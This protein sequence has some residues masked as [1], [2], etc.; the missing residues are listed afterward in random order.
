[1]TIL[2]TKQ[3][4]FRKAYNNL[5]LKKLPLQRKAPQDFEARW[6]ASSETD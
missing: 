3:E 2:S 4:N 1:M 5:T 6:Q